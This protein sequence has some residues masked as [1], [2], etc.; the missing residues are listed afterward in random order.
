MVK[1]EEIKRER[2]K[3]RSASKLE[4]TEYTSVP[5]AVKIFKLLVIEYGT[6]AERNKMAREA[7]AQL[8]EDSDETDEDDTGAGD[9]DDEDDEDVSKGLDTDSRL[10]TKSPFADAKLYADAIDFGFGFGLDDDEE[11]AE[12]D[13]EI[14]NDAIYSVDLEVRGEGDGFV[15]CYAYYKCRE[16]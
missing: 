9:D 14:R 2:I 7:V 10:A 4:G 12:E 11:D 8:A 16:M 3:T 6:A 15:Q 1:G 13:P 5:A